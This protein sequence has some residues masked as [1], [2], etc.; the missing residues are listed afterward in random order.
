MKKYK[1]SVVGEPKFN[2]MTELKEQLPEKG[3]DII[4]IDE[5]GDKYYCFRCACGNIDCKE[6]RCSLTGYG[7][8]ISIIKWEYIPSNLEAI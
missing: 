6:W 7:L 4:G 1:V 3:R 8:L 2:T 5:N